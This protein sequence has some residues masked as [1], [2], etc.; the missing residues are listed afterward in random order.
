MSNF[1]P[2]QKKPNKPFQHIN[3]NSNLLDLIHIDIY[4]SCRTP[5]SARNQYFITFIDDHCR[6]CYTYLIKS[7]VEVLSKFM[8]FKAKAKNQLGIMISA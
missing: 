7:K 3:Q 8:F 6:F 4:D 1:C 2:S 5:T